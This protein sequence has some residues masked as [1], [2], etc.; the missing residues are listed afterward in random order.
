MALLGCTLAALVFVL[1]TAYAVRALT[2]V[3]AN[4]LVVGYHNMR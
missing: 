3:R 4:M 1:E 2:S